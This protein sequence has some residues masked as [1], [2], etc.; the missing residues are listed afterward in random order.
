MHRHWV[1]EFNEKDRAHPRWVAV[2]CTLTRDVA[3]DLVE[4]FGPMHRAKPAHATFPQIYASGA[5][6]SKYP[7]SRGGRAQNARL[8]PEKVLRMRQAVRKT[9]RLNLRSWAKGY[10][11]SHV[12]ILKAIMGE[13][14]KDVPDPCHD[15]EM[16]EQQPGRKTLLTLEQMQA[17][18]AL[19]SA[20][21]SRWT[22]AALA[23]RSNKLYGTHYR[24]SNIKRMF[25]KH[26]TPVS[27]PAD[28]KPK[29]PVVRAPR[30][31]STRRDRYEPPR[32]VSTSVVDLS[33]VENRRRIAERLLMLRQAS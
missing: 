18:Y 29:Q 23:E 11:V 7:V 2:F 6:Y 9:R 13:T 1:I 33:D 14:F 17:L 3:E 21:P 30:R 32:L 5:G 26:F 31:P 25:E 19:R 16:T 4:Q 15:I 27:R 20:E 22:Y 12:T 10:G 8:T 28:A 24:A